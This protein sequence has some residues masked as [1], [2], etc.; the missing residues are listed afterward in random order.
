VE[1]IGSFRLRWLPTQCGSSWGSWKA[2]LGLLTLPIKLAGI[3]DSTLLKLQLLWSRNTK[4]GRTRRSS[5]V[6]YVVPIFNGIAKTVDKV[7]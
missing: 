6:Y 7:A 2:L 3:E 1:Y 4:R 5:N